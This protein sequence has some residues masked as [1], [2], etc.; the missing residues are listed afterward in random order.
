MKK[1][2]NY[3]CHTYYSNVVTT[4]CV[5]SR[6]EYAKKSK[7]LGHEWLSS[8]E[9]GGTFGWVNTYNIAKANGLKFICCGE[10]YFVPNRFEKDNKN[11]HLVLVAKTYNAMRELNYIMSKA[12]EDGYY[13]KPRVDLELLKGLPKGEVICTS[14][15]I[16]GMLRDYPQTKPLLEK[17]IEIFG[18]ENL[19]LEVQCHPIQKQIEYNKLMKELSHQ[20]GLKL[21][22]GADSHMIDLKDSTLR[23]YLL[24][25]KGIIYEDEQGWLNDFVDYEVFKQRF[26]QQNIWTEQEVE[27]FIDNTLLLT[28]TEEIN[29]NTKMKVPTAFPKK[30]REWKL[31]HFKE[32]IFSK[33]DE[34][35][36]EVNKDMW[37]TYEKELLAEYSVI[38]ETK[39]EDYF[40]LN[41]YIIKRGIELGGVLTKSSRGSGAS[42][43]TNFMLGFTS[44][45]R[46]KHKIPMLRER[47]MGKARIIENNSSPDID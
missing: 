21:I 40:L 42:Y 33:W 10:F 37:D 8:C 19:F 20:Y 1:Y 16:G 5:V 39:M 28:E 12:Y 25:S 6:E 27:S 24:H 30:S 9:H 41:Y 36:N 18:K 34:Y 2:F 47:F 29:I 44:I 23:D 11:Y 4:D 43:V 45:D 31:N 35:K 26:M 32:L 22:A 17:F 3:H 46:L 14:A 7:E 13:Y 38:E 15:C